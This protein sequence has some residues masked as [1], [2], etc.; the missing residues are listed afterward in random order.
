M[1]EDGE[2][3]AWLK[4]IVFLFPFFVIVAIVE[5]FWPEVIPFTLFQVW[6]FTSTTSSI[7]W[8][9]FAM[10]VAGVVIQGLTCLWHK[11]RLIYSNIRVHESLFW[12]SILRGPIYEEIY[13]RWLAF[14]TTMISLHVLHWWGILEWLYGHM[15]IPIATFMTLHQVDWMFVTVPWYIGGALI[16]VNVKFRDQHTYQGLRGLIT[17]WY[18]GVALFYIMFHHGLLVAI[19]AHS[20]YNLTCHLVYGWCYKT[21]MK[22]EWGI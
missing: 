12:P 9:L 3:F 16:S 5:Y 6:T 1:D 10:V 17:S 18:L 22:W 21:F 19:I 11:N 15:L 14:Y 20:L 4:S 8:V 7:A 13:Y 2:V